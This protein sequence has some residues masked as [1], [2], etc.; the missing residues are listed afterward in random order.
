MSKNVLHRG[1]V[2]NSTKSLFCCRIL[3]CTI[4]KSTTN[5]RQIFVPKYEELTLSLL[6]RMEG[7][8]MQERTR[9]VY[10]VTLDQVPRFPSWNVLC[11]TIVSKRHR[12][13]KLR[14]CM[15]HYYSWLFILHVYLSLKY[16]YTELNYRSCILRSELSFIDYWLS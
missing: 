11:V 2:Q 9:L 6:M 14:G 12:E 4:F 8:T 15:V 1:I 7:S 13:L 5:N 10:T 3:H 16:I